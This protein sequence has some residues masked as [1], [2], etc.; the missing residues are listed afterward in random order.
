MK[1]SFLLLLAVV[2]TTFQTHS[3]SVAERY[4]DYT[5]EMFMDMDF[6]PNLATPEVK[7]SEHEAIKKYVRNV[8]E[9][10][11][12]AFNIELMRDG[13]VMIVTIPADELFLPNDTLLSNYATGRIKPLLEPLQHPYMFKIVYAM[14][15]DN[16]GSEEYREFLSS[17]RVASLYDWFMDMIDAGSLSEDLVIIPYSMASS[18]PVADNDSR[19]G[20]RNNRRLEIY[21]VPGPEMI[22]KASKKQLK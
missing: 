13:E 3:Q 8:A 6:E 21:F 7:K 20:R 17:A 16:T 4:P 10:F 14:H 2:F 5:E 19:E 9:R 22:E 1:Q 18:S 11:K 12:K 15:T